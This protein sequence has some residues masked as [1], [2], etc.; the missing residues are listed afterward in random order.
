MMD[1]ILDQHMQDNGIEESALNDFYKSLKDN[2]KQY[3]EINEHT[4]DTLYA[5]IDFS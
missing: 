3:E 4:M 2:L 1:K 5:I